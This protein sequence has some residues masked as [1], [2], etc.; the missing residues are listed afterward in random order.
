MKT[1]NKVNILNGLILTFAVFPIIPNSI[2]GLP[3]IL[4]FVGALFF[5]KKREVNWKSLLVNS[6]L[7]LMYTISVIYSN[8][9]S[10]ALKKLETLN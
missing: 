5:F 4:L 3:V 1:I 2:K 8:D 10:V 9:H 6:S 7:F